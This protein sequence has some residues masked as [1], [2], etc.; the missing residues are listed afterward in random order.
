MIRN[1]KI[2]L[3][4]VFDDLSDGGSQI[5]MADVI[6]LLNKNYFDIKIIVLDKE[7]ENLLLIDRLNGFNIK[8]LDIRNSI[9]I[10]SNL[11]IVY[12]ELLNKDFIISAS[13]DS[14]LYCSI[15]KKYFKRISYFI[16]FTHGIDGYYINDEYFN[17][18][19][20]KFGLIYRIKERYLLNYY[21]K[22]FD[23]FITVC[24]S[25]K[26]YLTDIRNVNPDV[27]QTIYLGLIIEKYITLNAEDDY[28]AVRKSLNININDF[29]IIYSGRLSYAKGLER[30]VETFYYFRKNNKSIKLIILGNGELKEYL[31][32]EVIK[33]NVI[34]DCIFLD[35]NKNYIKYINAA[36][37]YLLPSISESTNLGVQEAMLLKKLVLSSDTGG[38]VELIQDSK[39]GFLFKCGDYQDLLSKLE[40][41]FKNRDEFEQLKTSS[42]D[43]ILNRFNL[44][45]NVK[46]IEDLL[47][48]IF[49]ENYGKR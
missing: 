6:T 21:L 12:K 5:L 3:C 24:D 14:N 20:N 48:G 42:K 41:I 11:M 7:I 8:N 35:Y 19:K 29:V 18:I 44:N 47:I 46:E 26:K 36:N 32:R 4:F 17:K 27:I 16:C 22:Y 30:L 39:N 1:N 43:E 40:Y 15:I 37:L 2:K 38:M 23:K 33:Y 10:F 28:N 49:R 34:D 13:S 25:L 45:K 9:N 31:V